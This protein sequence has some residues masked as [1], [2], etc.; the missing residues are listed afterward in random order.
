[1]KQ[2][3]LILDPGLDRLLVASAKG[4]GVSVNQFVT[5]LIAREVSGVGE[6]FGRG[7]GGGGSSEGAGV[8]VSGGRGGDGAVV[9]L[10]GAGGSVVPDWA[11]ILERGARLKQRSPEPVLEVDPLDVIA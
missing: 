8:G 9:G 4:A 5:D 6:Y 7:V 10:S 1:M 2:R 3:N 11:A